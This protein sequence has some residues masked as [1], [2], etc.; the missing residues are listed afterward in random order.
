MK[1]TLAEHQK[2]VEDAF[3]RKAKLEKACRLV[4]AQRTEKTSQIKALEAQIARL[5]AS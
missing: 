5:K 1:Q 3:A 4:Q 2:R